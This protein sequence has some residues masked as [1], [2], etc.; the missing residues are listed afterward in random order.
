MNDVTAPGARPDQR[1]VFR[2]F[3]MCAG[4][5][6]WG[7]QFGLI[8]A[9]TGTICG[10]GWADVRILGF[11]IVPAGITVATLAALA[12]AAA[13]LIQGLRA[14]RRDRA[15][16]DRFH[17]AVMAWIAGLGLLAIAYNGLPAFILPACA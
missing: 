16:V 15:E 8:Y 3:G 13:A 1:S 4:F 12:V 6:A 10:R 9:W 11:G 14:Y 2:L 7:A 17:H 5:L